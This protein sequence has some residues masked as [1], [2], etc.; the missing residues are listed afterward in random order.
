MPVEG[1]SLRSGLSYDPNIRVQGYVPG[2]GVDSS[3]NP[4]FET[5]GAGGETA[6]CCSMRPR[7]RS[8]WLTGADAA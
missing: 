1:D 7:S 8:C 5:E 4:Y 2:F 6:R 3:G